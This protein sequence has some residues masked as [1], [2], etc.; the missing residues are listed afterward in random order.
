MRKL[1]LKAVSRKVETKIPS[2]ILIFVK[3]C[4]HFH[5]MQKSWRKIP[6]I[7]LFLKKK[8]A[9]IIQIF[10]KQLIFSSCGAHLLLLHRFNLNGFTAT[11]SLQH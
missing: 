3:I 7:L 4:K 1:L 6:S 11:K 5:F 9:Q 10:A 2:F 8:I